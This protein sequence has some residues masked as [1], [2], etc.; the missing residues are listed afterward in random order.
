MSVTVKEI[1]AKYLHE[2]GYDG[3]SSKEC[4]C[5]LS[6]DMGGLF[7]CYSEG[8]ERC[9]AAHSKI[10][11]REDMENCECEEGEMIMVE[12]KEATP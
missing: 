9:K 1:V 12:T 3:L 5:W 4:G 6:E 8:S 10:A 2:N 11:T 7:P